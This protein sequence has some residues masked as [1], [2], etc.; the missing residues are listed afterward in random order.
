M[1]RVVIPQSYI[2]SILSSN[3]VNRRWTFLTIRGSTSPSRSRS[4]F[5]GIRSA[6]SCRSSH[7]S[8]SPVPPRH[9][10]FLV[11]RLMDHFAF[12]RTLKNRLR[13]LLQQFPFTRKSL[14]AS[15]A[16]STTH[17]STPAISQASFLLRKMVV[18][19]VSPLCRMSSREP[20]CG[21]ENV[22]YGLNIIDRSSMC[23]V[24]H[25]KVY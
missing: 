8:N 16:P 18:F 21:Q 1:S 5:P 4:S 19:R 13:Q 23:F 6:I 20:E 9:P 14:P 2:D 22:F 11:S 25:Y 7:S 17:Q 3:P 24:V 12:Q 15:H 10:V